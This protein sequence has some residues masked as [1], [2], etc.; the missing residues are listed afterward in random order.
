MLQHI[1]HVMSRF[2]SAVVAVYEARLGGVPHP[3]LAKL[4]P[5]KPSDLVT[6]IR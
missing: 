4:L 2:T 3:R 1:A 6:C 5:A